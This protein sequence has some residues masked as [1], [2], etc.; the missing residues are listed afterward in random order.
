MTFSEK[1]ERARNGSRS[2][3]ES[4]CAISVDKL[5]TAA[6]I[7][8]KNEKNAVTAVEKAV[9]DGFSGI[10]RIKDEKH[11]RS[12]L[13]HEVTKNSVEKLR[14]YKANGTSPTAS[15]V[16]AAS[17]KL[18]DVERL[19]FA[20]TVA[21]GFGIK[22]I[23]VLTGL[24]EE[25]TDE[26]LNSAKDH[27]G[28][29]YPVLRKI[30]AEMSAP[31]FL[32]EQYTD[33]DRYI[34]QAE[35]EET[36]KSSVLW[37]NPEIKQEPEQKPEIKQE[38]EQKP[39]MKQEPEQKPEMKQEP[40]LKPEIKQEPVKNPEIKQEPEQN[41]EIKQE[42]EQKPEIKQ[43]PVEKPEIKQEPVK[44]PEIKQ[45][46]VKKPEMRQKP[47]QTPEQS[48]APAEKRGYEPKL[49]AEDEGDE[50]VFAA[51]DEPD[52]DDTVNMPLNA[53]TFIAVVSA[54]KMKG[55]EFLRLIGNTRISNSAFREIETN[56]NL[57]KKRLIELL[58]QS[59]L[60]EADYYK[61]FTAIKDRR[62]VLAMKEES[63]LA[64][65]RA[66][67]YGG[68]YR[69][70]KRK[71][72]EKPKSELELAIG[73]ESKRSTDQP[74]PYTDSEIRENGRAQ[75]VHPAS[76]SFSPEL[77]KARRGS[78]TKSDDPDPVTGSRPGNDNEG[79]ASA[80]YSPDSPVDPFAAIAA[81]SAGTQAKP[82][83]PDEYDTVGS[84]GS[85]DARKTGTLEFSITPNA[86]TVSNTSQFDTVPPLRFFTSEDNEKPV[87][88]EEIA[89]DEPL[90]GENDDGASY[91]TDEDPAARSGEQDE[92][93]DSSPYEPHFELEDD[94][95]E[96]ITSPV[97]DDLSVTKIINTYSSEARGIKAV[98]ADEHAQETSAV[99]EETPAEPDGEKSAP[100]E[101]YSPDID[102]AFDEASEQMGTETA[103]E[104]IQ[105]AFFGK[106]F[107]PDDTEK[108][109][110]PESE[111]T[112]YGRAPERPPF[113]PPAPDLMGAREDDDISAAIG[114]EDSG[115]EERRYK[116]NKY[117]ID[118][119]EYYE[120]VNR[121]KIIACAV[122]AVLLIGGCA[123]MKYLGPSL[124]PAG[125][126]DVPAVTGQTE[127]TTETP[128]T[129]E[130]IPADT[131]EEDEQEFSG[132]VVL[133]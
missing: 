28:S 113:V 59:H 23:S 81:N 29:S 17:G 71:R 100:H 120:G 14:E 72:H 131:P 95:P 62:E 126:T 91:R 46:P 12:W 69:P 54:E 26:K 16:F 15:G 55:S 20:M 13:A 129:S 58:E 68:S 27:L 33:F 65:E 34:E 103:D 66:G 116:G 6:L 130:I 108:V 32:K 121:G 47:L 87:F 19:V 111:N 3:Y 38:P 10:D 85:K 119:D 51:P 123:G 24:S 86:L 73:L 107:T 89:G 53:A 79:T 60:T 110:K 42:P 77:R 39:E 132:E 90:A 80:P 105:L 109:S 2:A 99:P 94:E 64:L 43:E 96:I 97:S 44:N 70:K 21:F 83:R 104:D 78:Y 56:P 40:E 92:D 67:L 35:L 106:V 50:V 98:P 41:P 31:A 117:F 125:L 48:P 18:P 1:L 82:L 45:K 9:D 101:G 112:Q 128:Q 22:E 124:M 8:L 114:S 30:A 4:L 52:P 88:S 37:T 49:P 57:T 5:Y 74:L 36:R 11:L 133:K 127:Q 76:G 115:P 63:R 61:L 7:A 118:D 102:F 25:L 122:F 93:A 75:E 84:R